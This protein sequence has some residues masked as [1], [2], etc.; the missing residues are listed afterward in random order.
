MSASCI[1]TDTVYVFMGCKVPVH[2]VYRADGAGQTPSYGL[3]SGSDYTRDVLQLPD[4]LPYLL[5]YHV[6]LHER[7][8]HM[9]CIYSYKLS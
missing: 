5:N 4:W 1:L 9:L 2:P 6:V 7:L 3:L 8:V